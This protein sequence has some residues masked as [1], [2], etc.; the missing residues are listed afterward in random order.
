MRPGG[1]ALWLGAALLAG[2]LGIWAGLRWSSEQGKLPIGSQ[3]TPFTLP[4]RAGRAVTLP[5]RGRAVLIN[6]WAEWCGP[7]R[8]EMP[9]L[10]AYA[11]LHAMGGPAVVGIALDEAANTEA[12]LAETPLDFPILIEAPG[13]DDS[14]M[15]LG[16]SKGLLPYSV[17]VG[18]DGRLLASRV[19]P[20]KDE[21]DLREWASVAR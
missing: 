18:A 7:C 19:G 4:D 5:P 15:A 20:F 6:Y 11:R 3:V 12:F 14:S 21:T 10:N 1:V 2:G 17:L 16:D 8:Q 13:P 9:L